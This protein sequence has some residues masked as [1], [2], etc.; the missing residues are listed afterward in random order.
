MIRKSQSYDLDSIMDIWLSENIS[1]HGFIPENYWRENYDDVKL[2]IENSEVY[3][4]ELDGV[5]VG[6]IG[7]IE[8]YIAGL[9]VNRKYQS[10]GIGSK[11]LLHLKLLK[12]TLTLGVYEENKRAVNFYRKH[13]FTLR[14]KKLDIDTSHVECIM[15]WNC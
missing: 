8:N 3:V 2:A 5:V 9:F 7:V 14:E 6:F 12:S 11:L 13:G 10:L 15:I 4:Y 1:A